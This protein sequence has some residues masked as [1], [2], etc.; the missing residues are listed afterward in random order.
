MTTP[1]TRPPGY[2][3]TR[4]G[5][6]DISHQSSFIQSRKR[7]TAHFPPGIRPWKQPIGSGDDLKTGAGKIAA[8]LRPVEGA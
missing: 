3:L 5:D 7:R 6:E 2:G 1:R 4:R 8:V